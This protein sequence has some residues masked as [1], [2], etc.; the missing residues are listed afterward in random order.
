M[1]QDVLKQR[2]TTACTDRQDQT[3]YPWTVASRLAQP[4]VP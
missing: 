3:R 4:N 1:R 2:K